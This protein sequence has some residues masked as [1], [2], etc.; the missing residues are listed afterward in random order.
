[1]NSNYLFR[2]MIG[3]FFI[4]V[5]KSYEDNTRFYNWTAYLILNQLKE[6]R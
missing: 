3:I 4:K 1:M 6:V 5:I 2:Q